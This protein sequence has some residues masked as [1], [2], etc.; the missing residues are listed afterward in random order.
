MC[1]IPRDRLERLIDFLQARRNRFLFPSFGLHI[2]FML[3]RNALAKPPVSPAS[4][5]PE[6]EQKQEFQ[7]Q[8]LGA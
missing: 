8:L 4:R 7:V 6:E 3:P 1:E 2:G 5:Q